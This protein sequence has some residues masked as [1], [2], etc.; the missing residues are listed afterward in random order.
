VTNTRQLSDVSLGLL[1]RLSSF[2]TLDDVRDIAGD[3]SDDDADFVRANMLY[4]LMNPVSAGG[5]DMQ[6]IETV[7][8]SGV[9]EYT[10]TLSAESNIFLRG[11][12]LP[13]NLGSRTDNVNMKVN[14]SNNHDYIWRQERDNIQWA[15]FRDRDTVTVANWIGKEEPDLWEAVH[16]EIHIQKLDR[17]Y[18]HSL[19]NTT[20]DSESV[21]T[22]FWAQGSV[23]DLGDSVNSVK[24]VRNNT[25]PY[26]VMAFNVW[27]LPS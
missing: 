24:I 10:V 16:F 7:N 11:F 17:I 2:C 22:M 26:R 27:R 8:L 15:E 19:A 23:G 13:T 6:L 21:S 3:M 4:D 14:G 25:E 5:G 20:M 9:S 18:F 12:I 1:L